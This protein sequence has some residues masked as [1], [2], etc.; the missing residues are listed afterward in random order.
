M[1][2]KSQIRPIRRPPLTYLTALFGVNNN[3]QVGRMTVA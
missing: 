1:I 3:R 2:P